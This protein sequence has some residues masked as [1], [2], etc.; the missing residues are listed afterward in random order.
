MSMRIL[1]EGTC[2]RCGKTVTREPG[3]RWYD[4]YGRDRC[5][6]DPDDGQCDVRGWHNLE[7]PASPPLQMSTVTLYG[8]D[9]AGS[10][11]VIACQ[12]L[13][14][15]AGFS[16][17]FPEPLEVLGWSISPAASPPPGA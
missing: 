10:V 12:Q 1:D 8:R 5:R 11:A 13:P 7:V 14:S 4:F 3:G 9:A 6:L 16:E 17:E 2:R 15:G